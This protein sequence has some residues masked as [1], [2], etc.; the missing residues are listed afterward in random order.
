MFYS[1]SLMLYIITKNQNLLYTLN[2]P[3]V[4]VLKDECIERT[5]RNTYKSFYGV[6]LKALRKKENPVKQE[7]MLSE[8]SQTSAPFKAFKQEKATF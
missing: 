2:I 8:F 7:E 1:F 5:S 6:D 4:K 3:L